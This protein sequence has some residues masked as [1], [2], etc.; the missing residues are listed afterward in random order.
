MTAPSP[1]TRN[2]LLFSILQLL[3]AAFPLSQLDLPQSSLLFSHFLATLDPA[4]PSRAAHRP[5]KLDNPLLWDPRPLHLSPL[6]L[7][8]PTSQPS[9]TPQTLSNPRIWTLD[10]PPDLPQQIQSAVGQPTFQFPKSHPISGSPPSA[11]G[12]QK[13]NTPSVPLPVAPPSARAR[14]QKSHP[15]LHIIKESATWSL[16]P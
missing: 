2:Y 8:F 12:H 15:V 4:P 7:P 13:L 10:C 9:V 3:T 6:T 11:P 14:L 1:S 5:L 16:H